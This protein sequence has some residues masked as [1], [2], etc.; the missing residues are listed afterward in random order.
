MAQAAGIHQTGK[1]QCRASN[2]VLDWN[3]KL[4]AAGTDVLETITIGAD[5]LTSKGVEAATCRE[6]NRAAVS[7]ARKST[8]R[9]GQFV[10][11]AIAAGLSLTVIPEYSFEQLVAASA[12]QVRDLWA[13]GGVDAIHL[14]FVQDSQNML[15]ALYGVDVVQQE[16]GCRIPVWITFDVDPHGTLVTGERPE[17]LW[18]MLQAHD[19]IALGLATYGYG[20]DALR[21]LRDAS[22]VPVGLLLDPF[23]WAPPT[24]TEYR[25]IEWLAECLEPLLNERLLSFC[26]LS[27]TIPSIEYVS[28]I[29]NLIR[30]TSP[31]S[32]TLVS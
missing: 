32:C 16:S 18:G 28:V 22:G 21:R 29:S 9:S 3:Q 6:W 12:E 30:D 11:G 25:P 26:G 13:D 15:A 14:A 31:T 5:P 1:L 17:D 2:W 10:A 20:A 4:W 24:M 27:C 7:I 8:S 23:P 19:P